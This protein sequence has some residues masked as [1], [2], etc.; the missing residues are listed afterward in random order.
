M[1]EFKFWSDICSSYDWYAMFKQFIIAI[2]K[3]LME[4]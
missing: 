2:F 3:I 1:F 4:Y